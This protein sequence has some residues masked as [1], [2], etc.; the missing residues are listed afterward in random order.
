VVAEFIFSGSER[1]TVRVR[2]IRY[3]TSSAENALLL[4]QV[5]FGGGWSTILYFTNTSVAAVQLQVRFFAENGSPVVIP[6]LNAAS[7]A[8]NL[9]PRSTMEIAA[10]DIG[11]LVQGYAS[12]TTPD[13]V[14]GYALLR[15]NSEKFG[16]QETPVYFLSEFATSAT[17]IW[18]ETT[19][20]STVAVLNTSGSDATLGVDVRDGAG[21]VVGAFTLQLPAKNKFNLVLR[22]R[23][24]LASIAGKRG[25]AVFTASSGTLAVIGFRFT[26]D[27]FTSIPA[28]HK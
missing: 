18:D 12:A 1:R 8:F 11:S 2:S 15:R 4:P 25:S 23:P 9:E 17:L 10:P 14:V 6:G 5:V 26:R 19:S 24:E 20:T 22:E 16:I 27:S 21:A 7:A 28:L 13:S 3:S